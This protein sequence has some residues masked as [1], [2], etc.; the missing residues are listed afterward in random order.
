MEMIVSIITI[1]LVVCVVAVS[2]AIVYI[3]HKVINDDKDK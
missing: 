3:F 2:A 1:G